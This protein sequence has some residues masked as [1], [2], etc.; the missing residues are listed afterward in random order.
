MPNRSKNTSSDILRD[1]L[2]SE[3]DALWEN[4]DI[5]ELRYQKW[6]EAVQREREELARQ[7]AELARERFRRRKEYFYDGGSYC[8][9]HDRWHCNECSRWAAGLPHPLEYL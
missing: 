4:E 5:Q 1:Q 2:L 6:R 9:A 3:Y 7:L 8:R